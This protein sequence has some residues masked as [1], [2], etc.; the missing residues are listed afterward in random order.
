MNTLEQ[1]QAAQ[2]AGFEAMVG[3]A[4]KAIEGIEQLA[5][6]NLHTM[7][8]AAQDAAEGVRRALAARDLQELV[9]DGENPLQ[10]SGQRAADYAQRL[11]E[12]SGRAQADMADAL[13]HAMALMQQ[14]VRDN[15][16]RS[17]RELP[18]GGNGAQ[19]WMQSAL[20]IGTQALEALNKSQ[21]QAQQ[22]FSAGLHASGNSEAKPAARARAARS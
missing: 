1:L 14:A 12:I 4:D 15:V 19:A 3:L 6:L 18:N 13:S 20:H 8:D 5:L 2:R 10:R 7:R 21:Q 22:V 16:A 17:S 9:G 11:G